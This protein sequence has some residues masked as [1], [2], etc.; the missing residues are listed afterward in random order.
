MNFSVPSLP[1]HRSH[2]RTEPEIALTEIDQVMKA[3][4]RVDCVLAD[5]RHSFS[6]H[7]QQGI[8][9]ARMAGQSVSIARL[10][11]ANTIS[12]TALGNAYACIAANALRS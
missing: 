4:V 3:D 5:A 12:R 1:A 7:F 11:D 9:P 10:V 8:S 2:F 6:V